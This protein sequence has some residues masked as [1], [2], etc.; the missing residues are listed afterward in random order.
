MNHTGKEADNMTTVTQIS[1]HPR[2]KPATTTPPAPGCYCSS[3]SS[4]RCDFCTGLRVYQ[5]PVQKERPTRE[6]AIK[7]IKVALDK[8]S[9]KRWSVTGGRG[10]AWGWLRIDAP[11]AERTWTMQAD[12]TWIDTGEPRGDMSPARREE[13]AA[14]LGI[15][16]V[17]PQGESIPSG[18][19]YWDEYIERAETGTSTI[20]STPYWD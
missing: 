19:S 13:L 5:P 11:P 1:D 14:L 18:G 15:E 10:T 4:G 20:K 17:H 2:F 8:R 3:L 16:R 9:G 6:Q 7:R 12:K